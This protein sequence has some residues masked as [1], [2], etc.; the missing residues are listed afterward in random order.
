[1]KIVKWLYTCSLA[2]AFGVLSFTAVAC[3]DDDDPKKPEVG[4]EVET[5]APVVEYYIMGTVTSAGKGLANVDV[6]IGSETKKTDKDGKFA[7]TEKNTGTYAIEVTPDGYIAQK[8]SVVID[9]KAENRS[10]VTV[11]LA[12]TEQSKTVEVKPEVGGTVEDNSSSNSTIDVTKEVVEDRPIAKAEITIPE[13]ALTE[14]KNISVTTYVPAPEKVATEV[15]PA[16]E[17]KP[18]EKNIPLAAARF[19]PSGLIFEKPVTISIPNPIPDVTFAT[20]DMQLT[21][22][23]E[24]T[25]K[26]EVQTG[27]GQN[28]SLSGDGKY[29]ANVNH[30]SSYAIENEVTSTIGKETVQTAETLGQKSQDNSQNAKAVTGIVLTYKEKSGWEYEGDIAQIV[31]GKLQGA[32][33]TTINAM[34]S[35][36]KTRMYAL[37]GSASGVASTDRTY[38]TVNVNGYTKMDYSCY[39]KTRTTKLSTTIMY[40]STKVTIE[41][42]AKRYTGSDHQYKTVTS[43]PTHSGGQGGTH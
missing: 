12:L 2:I 43:N 9:A 22:L 29:Q 27:Q 36:L 10:V 38:N 39:A 15:D 1:M 19:E 35:Y 13:G 16:E 31:K 32:Q 14:T 25:G 17:N 41:I 40:K 23:N 5:P 28:V 33:Q 34:E 20:E 37:M 21:Y 26:W 30:F 18:V 42:S 7:V 6:K 4:E 24:K 8:T 3:H 11:A